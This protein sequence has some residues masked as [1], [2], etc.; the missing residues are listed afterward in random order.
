MV[1][2]VLSQVNGMQGLEIQQ[3]TAEVSFTYDEGVAS[4]MEIKDAVLDVGYGV[5]DT[6]D[7]PR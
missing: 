1:E 4:Y 6:E 3:D 2:R 7:N 5:L